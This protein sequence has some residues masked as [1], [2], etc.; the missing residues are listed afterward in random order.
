LGAL[1]S[2]PIIGNVLVFLISSV[3]SEDSPIADQ[4]IRDDIKDLANFL[5]SHT[6]Y[7]TIGDTGYIRSG[8]M[9]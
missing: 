1:S 6:C 4:T 7:I 3:L 2:I 8:P 9:R 5:L